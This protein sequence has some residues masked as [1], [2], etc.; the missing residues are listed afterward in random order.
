MIPVK[1]H[2]LVEQSVINQQFGKKLSKFDIALCGYRWTCQLLIQ[3]LVIYRH[4]ILFISTD[5]TRQENNY[6]EL[7][8]TNAWTHQTIG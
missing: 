7:W 3:N 4:R 6:F 8:L 5:F 2:M 1:K